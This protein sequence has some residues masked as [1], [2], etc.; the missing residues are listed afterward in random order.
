[1]RNRNSLLMTRLQSMQRVIENLVLE[2]LQMEEDAH[3]RVQEVN[4]LRGI[5]KRT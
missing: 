4:Q 1:M 5:A 2:S 3:D